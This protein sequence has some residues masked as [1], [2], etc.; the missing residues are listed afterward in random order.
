M[1]G[2]HY[3]T[4]AQ[5][6]SK[7]TN[8]QYRNL[9]SHSTKTKLALNEIDRKWSK[10]WI[11]T[12]GSFH[13]TKKDIESKPDVPSF[14]CL[15]QFPYPS[16]LLHMG[17]LRVYTISDVVARYKRLSGFNVI[18]PMGWDAFGLPAENAAVDRGINPA[19]YTRTNIESMKDQIQLMLA[20]FDW[21]REVTTCSP[22]YYKW[23]QKIFLMLYKHGLAYKKEAEINWDPVDQTVLANEQVD[24][25]GR[26]WR[27][28]AIVE[29]KN[30]NQWFIGITKYAQELNQDLQIL[31]QWPDKVKAMQKNWIGQSEGAEIMFPT[32]DKHCKHL[33]VYTSRPDTLFSVQFV[34]VALTHPIAKAAAQNDPGLQKFIKDMANVEPDS[35]EGYLLKNIQVSTPLDHNNKKINNFNVPVYVAP[36]VLGTYGHGAVM[37]C[38]GH[39]ERDYAFW[40]LHNPS[41]DVVQVVGKLGVDADDIEVPYTSKEGVLYDRTVLS[42][43]LESLGD[44]HNK[45]NKEAA[46]LI[47]E[48]LESNNLGSKSTQFRI[49]DWLISRQRFW[50]APIP[51]I[52][53]KSCGTVPV[54]DEQLPVLL[55]D[56]E[57]EVFGKGNP[58]GKTKEFYEAKCP[59][60]GNDATRET[61]TMDTFMDSSW[62]YFRYLDNKNESSPFD[63]KKVSKH[64]PVDI[65]IGGVEHAILHLLYSR[66]LSKFLGDI[67]TW[68]GSSFKNEPFKQL[69]TQGMVNGKTY[70]DPETGRFLKPEELDCSDSSQP[71]IIGSSVTPKITFEKMSKSK[72]N[73][74]DPAKCIQEYGADATRAHMLFLAP[75]SDELNWNEEQITGTIRWLE[76]V[77]N[78]EKT[79]TSYYKENI[80]RPKNDQVM[81]LNDVVFEN[82]QH[83]KVQFNQTEFDLY[84]TAQEFIARVSK[85]IDDMSLNTII[86]DYMKLT[87][88]IIAATKQDQYVDR[89]LLLDIYKKLLIIMS[90]VTPSVSEEC[91]ERIGT[92]LKIPTKSILFEQYP[93]TRLIK[94]P[95]KTY[96]VFINGKARALFKSTE[97]FTQKSQE[98]V[99]KE[100]LKDSNVEKF[101]PHGNVQKMIVKPG[102]ISLIAPKFKPCN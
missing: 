15:S 100:L 39:D 12:H 78:L 10:K 75:V 53:C 50:G 47:V 9:R 38:P 46:S 61:D 17:H 49:R 40:K 45:P 34:A 41:K 44:Y 11:E 19:V 95:Y 59:S 7:Y 37:G 16:G 87:N 80:E 82:N 77:I 14:Y 23:T 76:K 52:N 93:E 55:P 18:H 101:L 70:T 27:S 67:G 22:E 97:D 1:V 24:A 58:L 28:G 48:N 25:Q 57:G 62:Y 98:D 33:T 91:W 3:E 30:L 29:K 66:F 96:N 13:P 92:S 63:S 20:D 60:C 35:K 21:D 54:P 85:S 31:D 64:L 68:D 99:L 90:P 72:Y 79:I 4:A 88:A 73:G 5:S 71:K 36:Y 84:N 86:S 6:L 26:S 74:T 89:E 32:N 43:G 81:E 94:S 51:I 102:V 65:Y 42:N 69:V 8:F 2:R 56:L 83:A